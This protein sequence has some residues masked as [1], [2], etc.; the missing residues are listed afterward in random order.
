MRLKCCRSALLDYC[1]KVFVRGLVADLSIG[2][3]AN[4]RKVRNIV[5]LAHRIAALE[6]SLGEDVVKLQAMLRTTVIERNG[7]VG[8]PVLRTRGTE[9]QKHGLEQRTALVAAL[10]F[11]RR[12]VETAHL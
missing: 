1:R 11:F 10:Q 9:R 7:K 4:E 12:N 3:T 2:L 8:L 6:H 5:R